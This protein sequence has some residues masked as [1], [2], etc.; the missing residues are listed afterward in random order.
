[1]EEFL[2]T[3]DF[4]HAKSHH[5]SLSVGMFTGILLLL[6]SFHPLLFGQFPDL[7]S[8]ESVVSGFDGGFATQ[9]GIYMF[10]TLGY[11]GRLNWTSQYP[12]TIKTAKIK[13]G[14]NPPVLLVLL[15]DGSVYQLTQDPTGNGWELYG[16]KYLA[17]PPLPQYSNQKIRRSP[18]PTYPGG[19]PSSLK[20]NSFDGSFHWAKTA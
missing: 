16:V 1:M 20:W 14:S 4:K 19:S 3:Q 2:V 13:Q 9:N 7:P 5:R 17:Y 15:S 8:G 6:I 10:G 12:V 11:G 18:L